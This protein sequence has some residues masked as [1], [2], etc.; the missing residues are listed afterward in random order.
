LIDLKEAGPRGNSVPSG[1]HANNTREI[2]SC[3]VLQIA[4][5]DIGVSGT[6]QIAMSSGSI[7]PGLG[8]SVISSS[9]SDS[10]G[11][12]TFRHS[13]LLL[14]LSSLSYENPRYVPNGDCDLTRQP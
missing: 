4:A 8:L 2:P 1:Q 12:R 13:T 6:D 7:D 5:A 14:L 10:F 3:D 11:P 9:V